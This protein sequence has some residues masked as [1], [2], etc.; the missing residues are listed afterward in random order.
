M[1]RLLTQDLRA[2]GAAP[3]IVVLGDRARRNPR[4]AARRLE[5]HFVAS[6]LTQTAALARVAFAH[7]AAGEAADSVPDQPV[8]VFENLG[9]MYGTVDRQGAAAL[10]AA[11]EVASLT[12]SPQL[13]LI[14]P[15]RVAPARLRRKVTWGM[16]ALGIPGLWDEG[17]TGEGVLVGHLD[18][19]AD[20]GHPALKRAIAAF[21]ELDGFGRLVEPA[22]K[23]YDTDDHGTHT[24]ATIAGR[25]VRGMAVGVA[26]EARLASAIVIEGGET[27]ARVLGGLDWAVGQGVR[28]ISMS[29]GL[30]GWWEDFVPIVRLLRERNV[31]PVFAVGNEGPGTSRSP[32]NYP[33]ALS[34]GATSEDGTVWWKSSSQ[35]F[36]RRR[37]P[38]V[39]DIA[40]PGVGV[41]SAR[42]GGRGFHEMDGTSMATPHVAGLAALLLQA[43]PTA[44]AAA[45]QR[46]IYSSCRPAPGPDA[47]RGN[48]GIPNGPRALRA[49]R[50][51]RR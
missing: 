6:E 27:V 4:A 36:A 20:G 32:G 26:P 42:P 11:G 18:T 29:L 50:R 21:A 25:A 47:A 41:I 1:T 14:R 23:P 8:R 15:T 40:A 17:L 45:L 38:L 51:R 2:S 28:I 7:A 30:R 19:G 5:G 31:L 12:G 22:P 39:P 48:R 33:D 3:C 16:E 9:V 49:L 10:R 43:K 34:V 13:S 24:A 46:A 35:R 37:D 44:T